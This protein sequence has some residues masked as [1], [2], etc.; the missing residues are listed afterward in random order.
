MATP[1]AVRSLTPPPTRT[2]ALKALQCVE[3]DLSL[4]STGEWVPDK[5]GC[6]ASLEMVARVRAFIESLPEE[7]K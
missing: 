3:D 5:D 7:N 1:V 6:E 2:D 4:L